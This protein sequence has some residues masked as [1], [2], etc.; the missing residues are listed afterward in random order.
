MKPTVLPQACVLPKAGAGYD[1]HV[2][3]EIA[4]VLLAADVILTC[5]LVYSLVGFCEHKWN[6][7]IV[8]NLQMSAW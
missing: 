7:V 2:L 4:Q 1:R 8:Q 6:Q 5:H 3:Y